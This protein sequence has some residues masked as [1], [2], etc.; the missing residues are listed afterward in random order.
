MPAASAA[1]LG[2]EKNGGP[3]L[4]CISG[5]VEKPGVYEAPMTVTLREVIYG[6]AGG[7]RGGPRPRE[8]RR[9]EA[10]L[11]QRPRRK[12]RRVRS[13]DDGHAARV[14]LRVCRRHPRRASAPRRTAGR[15]STASAATSKSPACTKRR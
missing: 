3:K 8:E 9:A 11:H 10:L 4:Y 6:Y 5:H 15:S 7:V 12:A 1:G 14:D 2:P 13:A